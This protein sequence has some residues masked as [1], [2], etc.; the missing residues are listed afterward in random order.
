MI[1]EL[2][3]Q[4]LPSQASSNADILMSISQ[5]LR[6]KNRNRFNIKF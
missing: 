4:L 2:S 5:A 6:L 1:K 3:L